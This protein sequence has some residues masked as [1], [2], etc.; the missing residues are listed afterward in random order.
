MARRTVRSLMPRAA[1]AS[2]ADRG[3]VSAAPDTPPS[4]VLSVAR[5]SMVA[6]AWATGTRRARATGTA[7][8]RLRVVDYPINLSSFRGFGLGGVEHRTASA[9]ARCI[10]D[11]EQL[12]R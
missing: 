1:A 4:A 11:D 12:W 5:S 6:E 7:W 9:L 2:R 3:Q 8:H 10:G